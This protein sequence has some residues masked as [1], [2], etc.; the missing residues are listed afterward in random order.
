MEAVGVPERR[1][2]HLPLAGLFR[3]MRKISLAFG[4][5]SSSTS[6]SGTGDRR[7]RGRVSSGRNKRPGRPGHNPEGGGECTFFGASMA[8]ELPDPPVTFHTK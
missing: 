5:S 2:A 6:G 7:K 8:W 1:V 4:R 3:T